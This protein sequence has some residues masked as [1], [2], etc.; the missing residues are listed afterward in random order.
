MSLISVIVPIYN[1]EKYLDKCVES[2][3]NQTYKNLEIILVDDAS[4][5]NCPK[6]CDKWAEK[7]SR[8]KVIHKENGGVGSARNAG[9]EASKG[10][11]IG[12]VDGDDSID[13]DFYETLLNKSNGGYYD[14]VACGFKYIVGDI[15]KLGDDYYSDEHEFT[16]DELLAEFFDY[17]KSQWVSFCNKIIKKELFNN[18]KFPVDRYFEDW[19]LA[20]MVYYNA[21]KILYIP[22]YKYNYFIRQGSAVRTETIKRYHDCVLADYEHYLFFNNRDID[23]YNDKIKVFITSDF[24]KCVR[25]YSGAKDKTLLKEAYSICSKIENSFMLKLYSLLPGLF[26]KIYDLKNKN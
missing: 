5:D 13:E 18:L 4:P 8:I 24:K 2:I 15:T 14:V 3:V 17:C 21:D 11:W 16:K 7:D 26:R 25:V 1:V 9:L 6:I 20:P 23:I 22:Q 12:F 19:T 10:E